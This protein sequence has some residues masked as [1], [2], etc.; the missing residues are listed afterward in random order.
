MKALDDRLIAAHARGDRAALIA[1]YAQA[2]ETVNDLD[3]SC[4]YLTHAYV[5]A[6]ELGDGRAPALHARLK[7]EGREA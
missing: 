1:L 7:A 3:A 2:A 6:L 4:F 5:F